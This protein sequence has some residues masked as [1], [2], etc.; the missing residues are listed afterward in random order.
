[1]VPGVAVFGMRSLAQVVALLNGE[2]VPEAPPVAARRPASLLAV[3]RRRPGSRSST[4]TTWTAWP[5]PSWPW[6]SPPPAGTT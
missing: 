5:T 2:E 4:S 3:A 6:R 1:M